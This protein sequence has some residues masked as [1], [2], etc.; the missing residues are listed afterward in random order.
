MSVVE[1][2]KE[3]VL[4]LYLKGLTQRMIAKELQMSSRDVPTIIYNYKEKIDFTQEKSNPSKAF[5][6]Y[7]EGK[8]PVNKVIE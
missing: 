4:H 3:K 8:P 7:A 2:K 6:V 1:E 5:K